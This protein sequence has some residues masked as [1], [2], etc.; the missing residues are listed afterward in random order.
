[1][2]QTDQN[3]KNISHEIRSPLNSIIGMNEMILRDCKDETILG[4]SR[5]IEGASLHLLSLVNGILGP[6]T[7]S[8]KSYST[9][10]LMLTLKSMF[11]HAAE[12]KGVSLW[13][14]TSGNVPKKL[15]GNIT[16][17]RQ[18]C[19]NILSNALKYTDSGSVKFLMDYSSGNL[20]ITITDTGRGISHDDLERVFGEYER[21]GD[22][23]SEGT[24]LGLSI[25]KNLIKDMGGEM[26]VESI[27]D[28]GSSFTI[29]IPQEE[30]GNRTE[31]NA[32]GVKILL[33]DDDVPSLTAMKGMLSDFS[34]EA[35]TADSV[36]ECMDKVSNTEYDM[37][38]M[39]D[40]M[41]GMNGPKLLSRIKDKLPEKT[42]VI[43][44]TGNAAPDSEE[45]YIGLGFTGYISKPVTP[46]TLK[47]VLQPLLPNVSAPA[48]GLENVPQWLKDNVL[49]DCSEGMRMCGTW[50]VYEKTLVSFREQ[51]EKHIAA[52]RE[53]ARSGNAQ[54][55]AREIHSVK[56]MAALIGCMSLS[57]MAKEQEFN[58]PDPEEILSLY[59]RAA[60]SLF[61]AK[62]NEAPVKEEVD[63]DV[64]PTLFRHLE[65]YVDD[66][67][68]EAIE[69]MTKA[70]SK[71]R[72]PVRHAEIFE[73]F[74]KAHKDADW[75]RMKDILNKEN[76]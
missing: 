31:L 10:S 23:E 75:I 44:L 21:A 58:C 42:K 65:E 29:S 18:A 12:E 28:R 38:F 61:P 27:L 76:Q 26:S 54:V 47:K 15:K 50:Q 40:F 62:E 20:S 17:L 2:T 70:L 69:S 71:Y 11:S 63:E 33:V 67:N 35:D 37:I 25:T 45:R 60:S 41:P 16:S 19:I 34:A 14:S 1:M 64:I 22:R 53:A 5:A 57:R 30:T 49:I 9:D 46:E 3:V 74:K 24:G 72:F 4:Y 7:D 13:F 68:D 48:E 8:S 6:G 32:S 51:S 59:S 52:I 73:E 36:K 43:S 66:F 39:D 56:S 55:L